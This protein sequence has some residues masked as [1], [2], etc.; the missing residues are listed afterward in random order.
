MKA[1]KAKSVVYRSVSMILSILMI[2]SMMVLPAGAGSTWEEDDYLSLAYV[3]VPASEN[4][5]WIGT[6]GPGDNDAVSGVDVRYLTHINFAFGMIEAYQFDPNNPGRPLQKEKI[7]DPEAYKDLSDGQ[8]HYKVTLQGWIEEMKS[9]VDGRE[10]LRALVDLKKQK[11]SLKVLLSVGGWDSDGFCYMAKTPAGRA[12]FIQSCIDLIHEYGIDGIDLDWEY[13]EHG[14]W[15]EIA[16][17]NTCVSDGNALLQEMHAAF[18]AEW[19]KEHK[20]VTIASGGSQNW[21]TKDTFDALDY[22]NVMCY[23]YNPIGGGSQAPFDWCKESMNKYAEA[24]GDKK[25]LNLGVPFYNAGGPNLVPYWKDVNWSG[26]VDCNPEITKEKAE[27]VRDNDF[28]GCFYWNYS[29]DLFEDDITRLGL[30][31]S[32]EKVLQRAVYETLN[33]PADKMLD[34]YWA[35]SDSKNLSGTYTY[36]SLVNELGIAYADKELNGSV[37]A[38]ILNLYNSTSKSSSVNYGEGYVFDG[39]YGGYEDDSTDYILIGKKPESKI[40]VPLAQ[41][42]TITGPKGNV[43]NWHIGNGIIEDFGGNISDITITESGRYIFSSAQK[44]WWYSKGSTYT[45]GNNGDYIF[46]VD[47]DANGSVIVHDGSFTIDGSD[48]VVQETN[49]AV[50]TMNSNTDYTLSFSQDQ[51]GNT[52]KVFGGFE[53]GVELEL[54]SEFDGTLEKVIRSPESIYA[55]VPSSAEYTYIKSKKATPVSWTVSNNTDGIVIFDKTTGKVTANGTGTVT[56]TGTDSNGNSDSVTLSSNVSVY[57]G[58]YL[59]PDPTYSRYTSLKGPGTEKGR[60]ASI[61]GNNVTRF[62]GFLNIESSDYQTAEAFSFATKQKDKIFGGA[63]DYYIFINGV[64]FIRVSS[65]NGK[66]SLNGFSDT[67]TIKNDGD[68]IS[69]N[70][71]YSHINGMHTHTDSV[72]SYLKSLLKIGANRIDIIASSAN[73]TV[74]LRPCLYVTEGDGKVTYVT[75]VKVSPKTAELELG[76]TMTVSAAVTPANAIDGSV[77]WTSSNNDIADVTSNGVVRAKKLGQA[78]ITATA[79]AYSDSA[80]ITVVPK[81]AESITVN[82]DSV[83]LEE[84]KSSAVTVTVAPDDV[85]DKSYTAVSQNEDIATFDP[86]TNTVTAVSAGKTAI[87]FKTANG[88]TAALEVTVTEKIIPVEGI[89]VTPGEIT[90][91]EDES[92]VLTAKV[93]PDNATNKGVI[94]SIDNSEIAKIDQNGNITGKSAGTAVVTATSADGGFTATA[95]VTVTKKPVTVTINEGAQSI[96]ISQFET[97]LL[98]AVV[99]PN[100]SDNSVIW[101]SS[102]NKIAEISADGT[103]KGISVGKAIITATSNYDNTVF[104]TIEVN[105]TKLNY[106]LTIARRTDEIGLNE[107]LTL[108]PKFSVDIPDKSYTWYVS[109]LTGDGYIKSNVFRPLK[110]GTV[111]VKI[112]SNYDLNVMDSMVITINENIIALKSISPINNIAEV[113]AGK[114][115]QLGV[116]YNPV[117]ATNKNLKWS[118]IHPEFATV[119]E[120]GVVTGVKEGSALIIAVS[121]DGGRSALFCVYIKAPQAGIIINGGAETAEMTDLGTLSLTAT[122]TNGTNTVVWSSSDTDIATVSGDGTVTANKPGSVTITA[123]YGLD[124]TKFDTITVNIAKADVTVNITSKTEVGIG[125]ELTL[126]AKISPAVKDQSVVWTIESGSEFAELNGDKLTGLAAGKVTVTATSDYD[127]TKSASYEITVSE[128]AAGSELY[129]PEFVPGTNYQRGSVV[130]YEG[131]YYVFSDWGATS[132][133]DAPPAGWI[134]VTSDLGNIKVFTG[135]SSEKFSKGEIIACGDKYYTTLVFDNSDASYIKAGFCTEILPEFCSD[136]VKEK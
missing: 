45:M 11:P 87:T 33:G 78:V 106:T 44:N 68:T 39:G 3:T 18:D 120:N 117:N 104:D 110:A 28:G 61:N 77:K 10:Y 15:G 112:R 131:S 30:D 126:T 94:W 105:V 75:D 136:F 26:T 124:Q 73:D 90:V 29:M 84:G 37:S 122:V 92:A 41:P 38:D 1:M 69:N 125:S 23:D 89:T 27:W 108:T 6:D 74:M 123:K 47:V 19:P 86:D 83:I 133:T 56:I 118:S 51:K 8:Y 59:T 9:L 80:V 5:R 34:I 67:L 81:G 36:D 95:A 93:T 60:W 97:S 46:I 31:S 100:V 32:Q 114:T 107:F 16:F 98:S 132:T 127:N 64:P 42:I 20:L 49:Y 103:V 48:A 35:R 21:I 25:K 113:E 22:V 54:D 70:S 79:G 96:S 62:T 57:D 135:S 55:G 76:K 102:D 66:V 63:G 71:K 17:C 53:S 134:K 58:V 128:N 129:A 91:E 50:V 52:G 13:P 65:E 115:V 130:Y 109:P 99:A 116:T 43:S 24:F 119:D 88:K 2:V 40:G 7:A 121:E 72:Q 12:E 101:S 85:A 14:G 82:P 4:W 111:K